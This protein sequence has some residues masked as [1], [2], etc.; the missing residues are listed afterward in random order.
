MC[1]INITQATQPKRLQKINAKFNHKFEQI[2]E[3]LL[4]EKT[5]GSS[6]ATYLDESSVY[7]MDYDP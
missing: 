3:F 1:K 5:I 4:S 7:F 6:K 2:A